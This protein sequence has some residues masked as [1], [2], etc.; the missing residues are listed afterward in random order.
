MK[1]TIQQ[2]Q[3]IRIQGLGVCL[4]TIVFMIT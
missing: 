2:A 3:A 4:L 1:P